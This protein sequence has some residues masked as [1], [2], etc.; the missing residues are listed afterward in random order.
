[1][2]SFKNASIFLLRVSLGWLFF[3]AG[4]TKVLDP[5]WSAAGYLNN[6]S[7]FSSFFAWFASP[8]ILPITNFIN[9]WGLTLIG[10]ALILGIFVRFASI[11]GAVM[12][13]LYYFPV[14]N[15]PHIPPHSYIVDEH[16]VYIFA[17]LV[18]FALNA[19]KIFG[20]DGFLENNKRG[21][22]RPL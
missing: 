8:D 17:F 7:T 15:F 5:S 1:M 4:I 22:F 16:I 12:M 18:L 9:Q 6:A 11:G 2:Y 14:L 19:G 3:Y 20:L 13:T 10:V 21:G